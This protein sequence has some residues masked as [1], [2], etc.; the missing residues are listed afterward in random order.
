MNINKNQLNPFTT[1]SAGDAFTIDGARAF[2]DQ[3]S[4][5]TFTLRL[6]SGEPVKGFIGVDG[7]L[8]FINRCNDVW[9]KSN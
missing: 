6:E 7:Q 5:M 3:N 9:N 1:I 2:L 4:D 8:D